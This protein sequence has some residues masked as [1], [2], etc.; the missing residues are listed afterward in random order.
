LGTNLGD[1]AETFR[2]AVEKLR[3]VGKVEA[4]STIYE[5]DPVGYANQPAYLNA[6]ARVQTSL[7]P[8]SLLDALHQIE[9]ELGRTRSFRNAPRTLDLDLLFYDVLVIDEPGLEVPHPRLH[10]R[11][12]VLVPL[13]EFGAEVVHPRLHRTVADLLGELGE[14]AG[15]RPWEQ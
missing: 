2:V 11:A 6:V 15:V 5:T 13:A 3:R 1:R 10:E 14:I 12:F 4:V 7:S 8:R 9:V